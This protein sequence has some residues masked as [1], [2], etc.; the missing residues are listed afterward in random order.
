MRMRD[1]AEVSGLPRTTIHYYLREGLLPPQDKSAANTGVYGPEHV[2]RLSLIRALRCNELGPFTM[3]QIREILALV[4]DGVD[5]GLAVVTYASGDAG[6]GAGS[7]TPEEVAAE[8]GLPLDAVKRLLSAGLIVGSADG[9]LEGA[10]LSAARSYARILDLTGLEPEDLAPIGDL[11]HELARYEETI[12]RVA[13][14]RVA[15]DEQAGRLGV[16][17]RMFQ[18]VHQYL[19]IRHRSAGQE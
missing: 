18:S 19:I 12:T 4:D 2:E 9:T 8:T 10:D 16:L 14:A 17:H 7:V 6:Q 15:E 5:P 1:L 13:A 3:R 11:I